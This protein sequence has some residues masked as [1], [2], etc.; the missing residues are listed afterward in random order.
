MI[1]GKKVIALV[2]MKAHS[3]RI[4]DKN[5][6]PF[7]GRPLYHHVLSALEDTAEI[8]EIIINT[9]SGRIAEEA[10]QS[11]SRVCIHQRPD[12]LRGDHVSM[13]RILE[14]DIS[15]SDGDLYLQTHATNPLLRS[16]T[17]ADALEAFLEHPEH[18]SLFG[19][20][21]YRSRFYSADGQAVN[22][23]PNEL[24][25][26][27][28]LPP[29]FEENSCIYIFTKQSFAA[30]RARIGSSPLLFPTPPLESVDI[31]DD[32]SWRLAELICRSTT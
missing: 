30:T 23:D 1:R 6:R 32:A 31:D 14:H 11:F 8:D 7:C 3:E 17:Y 10:P 15:R 21:A 2:P 5:I 12:E 4:P 26:T 29:L 13:N 16:Q 28:D 9:D 18:D 25:R 27:Q 19:V 20:T 24:L 22:H